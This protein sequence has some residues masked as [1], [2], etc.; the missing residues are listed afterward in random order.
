M[1]LTVQ[2]K[3]GYELAAGDANRP[4]FIYNAAAAVKRFT[5]S[6]AIARWVIPPGNIGGT[7][8]SNPTAPAIYAIDNRASVRTS[9]QPT[10][11]DVYHV[12]QNPLADTGAE[13]V[14]DCFCI[15]NHN[16]YT[17]GIQQ[18]S[19]QASDT[20]AAWV[21]LRTI[22]TI[23]ADNPRIWVPKF[24]TANVTDP[25][26]TVGFTPQETTNAR[27]FRIWCQQAMATNVAMGEII[28][29]R[30]VWL[31]GNPLLEWD[32]RAEASSVSTFEAR[33]G[34]RI[35]YV[36]Y[37]GQKQRT[38]SYKTNDADEVAALDRLWKYTGYGTGAF[39]FDMPSDLTSDAVKPGFYRADEPSRAFPVSWGANGRDWTFKFTEAPP[40]QSESIA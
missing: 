14:V 11:N 3:S 5:T 15:I 31:K 10:F 13:E 7:D 23:G 8:L 20:Q 25:Y 30:S 32:D 18:I 29:G 39:L 37:S 6:Q 40:F 1:A 12:I 4:R 24:N 22:P 36:K 16:F 33:N 26:N 34:D 9:I 2:D 21:T 35:N 28:W 27:F 17:D 38:F 19:F